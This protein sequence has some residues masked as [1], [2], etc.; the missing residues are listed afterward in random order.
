[1]QILGKQ[2]VVFNCSEGIDFKVKHKL[3]VGQLLWLFCANINLIFRIALLKALPKTLLRDL[4]IF[5]HLI[6]DDGS[7]FQRFITEWV[8]VLFR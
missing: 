7:V 5:D 8:M 3:M 2:C 6:L 1:M 4:L